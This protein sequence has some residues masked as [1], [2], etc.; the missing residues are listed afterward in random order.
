MINRVND[1]LKVLGSFNFGI[2]FGCTKVAVTVQV[3]P[4]LWSLGLSKS[5]NNF[6]LRFGPLQV[7]AVTA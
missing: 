3:W 7:S 5:T 2:G 1:V 4:L 6:D